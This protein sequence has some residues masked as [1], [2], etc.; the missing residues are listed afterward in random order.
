M[1]APNLT[2][3]QA[4][5]RAALL[6]VQ[7]YDIALDLTGDGPA[8]GSTTTVRFRSRTAGAST[9]IDL[10]AGEVRSAVLNGVELDVSGYRDED[11]VVL[12]EL[13]E[14]NELVVRAQC[15]YTNTGEGLHRF[16]DP[17]DKG[18]YLYTQF[19]TADAKR[20]F[21]C[22]DQPDLKAVYDLTVTAPKDWKVMSN[23]PST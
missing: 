22:F 21:T 12:P 8:F 23:A 20:M 16:V 19:E 15:L 17:V 14:Q 3:D 1:A 5:Q 6:E 13:A 9:W 11:G 4:Q 2:R 10:V 7:S 18:V